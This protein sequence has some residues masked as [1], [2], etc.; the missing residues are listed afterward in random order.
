MTE[1]RGITLVEL[2]ATL[3]LTF[4][5]GSV[6]FSVTMSAINNYQQSEVQSQVQSDLNRFVAHLTDIH[7]THQQYSI[8]RED[9]S[10]YIIQLP[11]DQQYTFNGHAENYDLYIGKSIR[12]RGSLLSDTRIN[13]GETVDVNNIERVKLFIEVTSPSNKR[14]KPMTVSTSISQIIGSKDRD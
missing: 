5:V 7:Q 4:I 14:F 2:L 11:D 13:I 8:T 12:N 1:E 6:V 3:V 10:T 9:A